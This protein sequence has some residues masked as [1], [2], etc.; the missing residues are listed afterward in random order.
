MP[1]VTDAQRHKADRDPV[2]DPHIL[3]LEFWEDGGG[4]VERAAVN[5]EDVT[6]ESNTFYRSG[7]EVHVPSSGENDQSASLSVS[8]VDRVIGR[9]IDRARNRIN[10]RLIM[11]DVSD[12]STAI[13][14][15][16]NLMVIP[17]SSGDTVRITATL[18]PRAEQ[19]EPVPFQ[20][21]TRALF[22]GVW[23]A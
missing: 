22:P 20:R 2:R 21:T 3:L 14:D 18:G 19:N 10:C 4:T 13:I 11:V 15:T 7:I 9:A 1:E 17:S 12:L 23:F 5:N 16:K 8:N 6:F